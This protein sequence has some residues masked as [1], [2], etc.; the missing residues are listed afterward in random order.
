MIK[1]ENL[2]RDYGNNRGIFD[3][4]MEIPKGKI[5]GFIGPNGAGKTT[6]IKL[7]CG[8]F[9]PSSGKAY[10]GDV[11][12]RRRNQGKIKR[13][14]GYMPDKT[15]VYDQMSVWEY[16]DFFCAAFKIPPK[17]RKSRIEGV[18][19][20]ADAK[21]MLDYQVNSLSQGMGKR[22]V[23]AKTLLHDPQVLILDE[24]ASGLDPYAR[25]EMRRTI[26]RLREYGKTIM[27]SSHILPELSSVCDLAGIVEKGRLLAFGTIKEIITSLQ[28]NIIL[29]ITIQ[30]ETQKAADLC[31]NHDNI[32]EVTAQGNEIRA[33]YVGPRSEI[34]EINQLLVQ[35]Q[36]KVV[37]FR[38]EEGDLEEAFLRVTRKN[39][40][41]TRESAS[42]EKTQESEKKTAS[43]KT[44]EEQSL[45]DKKPS[46]NDNKKPENSTKPRLKLKNHSSSANKPAEDKMDAKKK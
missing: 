43:E 40:Q 4:N 8:L 11:E 36:V 14:I 24:P 21:Y 22:V 39:G 20:L 42:Q 13:M 27:L 23:L 44:S 28:E 46:E 30:G 2:T 6:T 29:S 32:K 9:K 34:A 15:G 25:I 16:L 41:Q 38:E 17:Q 1:T 33:V 19:E 3:L 18:L 12:V 5:F 26:T 45:V 10:I 37:G 7:L 35:N 31:S